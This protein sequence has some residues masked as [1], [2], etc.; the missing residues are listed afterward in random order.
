K[1]AGIAQALHDVFGV[2]GVECFTRH[3]LPRSDRLVDVVAETAV[4]YAWRDALTIKENLQRCNLRLR[5]L[6]DGSDW[7]F[8]LH[9]WERPPLA[10]DR[11]VVLVWLALLRKG[12]L[13]ERQARNGTGARDRTCDSARLAGSILPVISVAGTVPVFPIA[14]RS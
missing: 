1:T 4:D 10:F 7:L 11:S 12:L 9:L 13:V 5:L 8:R 14:A 2:V 3:L 6:G